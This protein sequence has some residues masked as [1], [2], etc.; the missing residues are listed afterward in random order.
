MHFPS[1]EHVI[2]PPLYSASPT[3]ICLSRPLRGP[4]YRLAFF[5]GCVS[6]R[7]VGSVVL[8]AQPIWKIPPPNSGCE[9]SYPTV[10]TKITP[11]HWISSDSVIDADDVEQY[12][13]DFFFFSFFL[14]APSSSCPS[15]SAAQGSH[16]AEPASIWF[17]T[18]ND[19]FLKG[20]TFLRTPPQSYLPPYQDAPPKDCWTL[21]FFL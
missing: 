11:F 4:L 6:S 16:P 18:C 5:S 3:L 19:E 2:A 20:N 1:D 13:D 9:V 21:P 7:S 14:I 10:P 12:A 17:S 15:F 8:F